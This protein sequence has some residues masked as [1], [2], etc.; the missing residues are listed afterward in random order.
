MPWAGAVTS[1]RRA[2]LLVS[3]AAVTAVATDVLLALFTAA[4]VAG[5]G[6][7]LRRGTGRPRSA[8][9]ALRWAPRARPRG[10]GGTARPGAQSGAVQSLLRLGAVRGA[11]V[12]IVGGVAGYLTGAARPFGGASWL[13]SCSSP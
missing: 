12:F 6:G 4:L 9:P 5:W 3:G 10:C 1:P 2:R 11:P 7:G 13:A 8:R